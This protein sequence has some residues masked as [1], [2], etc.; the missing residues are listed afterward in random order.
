MT[1]EGIN[2]HEEGSLVPL[3]NYFQN[4]VETVGMYQ[5]IVAKCVWVL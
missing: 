4:Q 1:D 3:R 2:L 5:K